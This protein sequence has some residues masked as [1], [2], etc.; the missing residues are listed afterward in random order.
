[1]TGAKALFWSAL[2]GGTAL[3]LSTFSRR[4]EAS[5][6]EDGPRPGPARLPGLGDVQ[7]NP[8]QASTDSDSMTPDQIVVPVP[9]G[10]RPGGA[11]SAPLPAWNRRT[12]DGGPPLFIIDDVEALARLITSEIGSGSLAERVA[13]GWVARNRARARRPPVS[14]ARLVCAPCG[15]SSGN[16]RPFS[17]RVPAT[18]QNRELAAL[19]LASPQSQDPTQGATSCFEPGLQDR[20]HAAGRPGHQLDARGVRYC[21]LRGLDFY[22]SVGR[23]DLFGPKGGPGARSVP[24]A[25]NLDGYAVCCSGDTRPACKGKQPGDRLE[26]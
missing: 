11:S 4:A 20:L 22:G 16:A 8:I 17:T 14:I 24:R 19:I 21:W 1:M 7:A 10:P 18:S 2:A 6:R 23:W 26:P 12:D 9:T 3:A 5:K 13:L 15:V 25:W